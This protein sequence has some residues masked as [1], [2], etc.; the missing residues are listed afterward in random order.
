MSS[1]VCGLL[2]GGL[3]TPLRGSDLPPAAEQKPAVGV[4]QKKNGSSMS[5]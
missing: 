4:F 3:L 2:G 5:Q 1:K